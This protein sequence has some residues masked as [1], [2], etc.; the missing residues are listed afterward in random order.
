MKKYINILFTVTILSL[1]CACGQVNVKM[2]NVRINHTADMQGIIK[3]IKELD[4]IWEE[5]RSILPEEEK[6]VYEAYL[7]A[8][9]DEEHRYTYFDYDSDG[10]MELYICRSEDSYGYV[11]KYFDG[12]LTTID[13]GTVSEEN[14]DGLEWNEIETDNS[15]DDENTDEWTHE[16]IDAYIAQNPYDERCLWY[17]DED[18]F[19][20]QYGFAE[21]TPFYEYALP[22]GNIRLT[23]YYDEKTGLGCGIRHF[24]RDPSDIMTSGLCG[25]TFVGMSDET[26]NLWGGLSVDYT[27]FESCDGDN[28]SAYVSAYKENKEYNDAGKVVHFDSSGL[29]EVGDEKPSYVLWMDYEYDENGLLQHRQYY[30]NPYIFGTWYQVW[31]SYF[32]KLGRLEH[33]YIYI[34]HGWMDYYY[35]YS[36]ESTQPSYC[37]FLDDNL[38]WW[39]PEF[40]RY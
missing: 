33:E 19:L 6:R 3:S 29:Y 24:E 5:V 35:I 23:L 36:D 40:A 26:G 37:L 17:M 18:S 31:D 21:S 22:D 27:K 34:T 9:G 28:G 38:G 4:I 11:I 8:Y 14:I 12:G 13:H 30:H 15:S 2:E 20:S 25:F 10:K 16:G 39:M 32:D 1:T 7:A